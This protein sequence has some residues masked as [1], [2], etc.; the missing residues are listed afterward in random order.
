VAD[1]PELDLDNLPPEM[2]YEEAVLVL[3]VLA[4]LPRPAAESGSAPVLAPRADPVPPLPAPVKVPA[5]PPGALQALVEFVSDALVVTDADGHIVLVN[6]QTEQL[7]GYPRGELLG[8]SVEL[9]VPEHLRAK[10]VERRDAFMSNA[11][12]RPMGLGLELT[13]RRKDG[14]EVPIEIGLSPLST[15]LGPLVVASIRDVSERRKTEAELKKLEKRYRTLVEEIPA[16]TFLAAMDGSEG[17][18]YVSPHIEK[19]LGFTQKEWVED[20]ILW[21]TQLH[22]DDRERWHKEF[23]R[24]VS[25]GDTFQD[26]YRFIAK[27][28]PEHPGEPPRVVWV[29]G[30]AKLVRDEAGRPLF[31]QG[32]AFDITQIKEAEETLRVANATLEQRVAERTTEVEAK[33]HE[34]E[35][36]NQDLERFAVIACHDLVKPLRN[37]KDKLNELTEKYRDRLEP[38]ECETRAGLD[39]ALG[40]A[41]DM[42]NMTTGLFHFSKV[43]LDQK[44]PVPTSC[45]KA[46]DT[47]CR[48]L[49]GESD[50][51]GAT[52]DRAN[53]NAVQ[54]EVLADKE[55]LERLF[56]NLIGNSLKFRTDD[57]PPVV[58]ITARRD[59]PMWVI[60][61][62]DNGVGIEKLP[63]RFKVD[64][65][66]TIFVIGVKSRWHDTKEYE[67]K[68]PGSGIGLTT[69]KSIV[70]RYGGWIKAESEGKGKG[71]T[72]TFAL[73]AAD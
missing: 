27:P 59:G 4:K 2:S 18:I 14:H 10:H 7:F 56:Q 67:G 6:A 64:P 23:A 66:E 71:T 52:I 36:S 1:A 48:L 21:Y 26:D 29:R 43:R 49:Q 17:E 34:L 33:V 25:R 31:L 68:Y 22:P 62:R 32:V 53:L 73:P 40:L 24:T 11:H 42:D 69:C 57:R 58:R 28:D 63:P 46:A 51:A 44:D 19:L 38:D 35:R 61:V 41:A 47:A 60:E 15:D 9:L 45:T 3:E 30:A 13:G 37:M 65:F 70:E 16:V 20:P 39:V 54:P 8:Q 55:Q 5:L 50:R 72:I 12:T